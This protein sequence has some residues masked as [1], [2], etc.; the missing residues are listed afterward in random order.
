MAYSQLVYVETKFAAWIKTFLLISPVRQTEESC[1]GLKFPSADNPADWSK[2]F[3]GFETGKKLARLMKMWWKD[4]YLR[5]ELT[6]DKVFYVLV[7]RQEIIVNSK[8][9]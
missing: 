7:G 4:G 6:F 8:E 5:Q 2:V 1:L 3:S 9:I